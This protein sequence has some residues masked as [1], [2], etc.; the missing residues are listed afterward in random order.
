M[1]I[2]KF[3]HNQKEI[4]IEKINLQDSIAKFLTET[5]ENKNDISLNKDD[6]VTNG[7]NLYKQSL[8]IEPVYFGYNSQIKKFID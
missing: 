6:I 8:D 1:T 7:L 3:L 5:L 2:D 4:Y